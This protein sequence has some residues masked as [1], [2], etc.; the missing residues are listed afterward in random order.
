MSVKPTKTTLSDQGANHLNVQ[1]LQANFYTQL[2][3]TYYTNQIQLYRKKSNTKQSTVCL[4]GNEARAKAMHLSS[5]KGLRGL[6][7][8]IT[9]SFKMAI[10][11]I[12]KSN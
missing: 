2:M 1:K 3:E 10:G 7:I 8:L 9:I 12:T 5:I 11:I 6:M 4:T